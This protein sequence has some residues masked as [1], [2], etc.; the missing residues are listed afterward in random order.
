VLQRI[1]HKTEPAVALERANR[2]PGFEQHPGLHYMAVRTDNKHYRIGIEGI[3]Y[4]PGWD[5][6]AVARLLA[7][8]RDLLYPMGGSTVMGH[9][10][11]ASE[12][13]SA[14]LNERLGAAGNVTAA[15]FR[16]PADDRH[17]A[18]E[19][20]VY[21]LRT[22]HRPRCVV[23]LDGWNDVALVARSNLRWQNKVIFH[24]S[25]SG[26]GRGTSGPGSSVTR[27]PT[28][29][30]PTSMNSTSPP[31]TSSR[32]RCAALRSSPRAGTRQACADVA[33]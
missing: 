5:D 33:I 8:K 16:A 6:T 31:A 28:A 25:A 4:E 11:S 20:L 17:R 19:K 7:S 18:V 15:S 24:G 1:H 32:A 26:R 22:S 21:L 23:F 10:V 14:Y 3:R 29:V 9:G 30:R 2:V 13:I 12:T 27:W